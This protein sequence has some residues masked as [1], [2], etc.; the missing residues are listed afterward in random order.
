MCSNDVISTV[1]TTYLQ[2]VESQV[3]INQTI[4]E[5]EIYNYQDT[6]IP[7]PSYEELDNYAVGMPDVLMDQPMTIEPLVLE[8]T[9]EYEPIVETNTFEPEIVTMEITYGNQAI[10]AGVNTGEIYGVQFHAEKS[11]VVGLDMIK[12]FINA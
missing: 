9:I 10:C 4:I 2:Y 8:Q 1:I 7:E 11:G 5:T 3:M 6:T 12:N